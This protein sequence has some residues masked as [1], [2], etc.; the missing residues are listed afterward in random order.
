MPNEE[1]NGC[2]NCGHKQ[3]RE[4]IRKPYGYS[5]EIPCFTCLRYQIIEDRH[6]N[7]NN[8][9]LTGAK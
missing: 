7:A 8:S 6:T 5:G 4:M 3:L 9:R 1:Q 2:M